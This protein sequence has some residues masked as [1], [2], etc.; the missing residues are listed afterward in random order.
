MQQADHRHQQ[1]MLELIDMA[2]RKGSRAPSQQGFSPV[3]TEDQFSKI[4]KGLT[5]AAQKTYQAVPAKTAWSVSN[6]MTE[7]ARKGFNFEKRT[8]MEALEQLQGAGVV[9][10][11]GAMWV[12]V[13]ISGAKVKTDK[14]E[15]PSP[16]NTR[17]PIDRLFEIVS[18]LESQRQ[19]TGLL[20][21][22]FRDLSLALYE[23]FD[24]LRKQAADAERNAKER[25]MKKFLEA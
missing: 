12:R 3:L 15:K 6:I 23:E 7:L 13:K 16:E 22:E 24:S 9:T 4:H 11:S 21:S 25:I 14:A 1:A 2:N 17:S 20:I 18:E 19:H 5:V 10:G 8:V